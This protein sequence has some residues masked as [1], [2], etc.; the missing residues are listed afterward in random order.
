MLA[1]VPGNF[2]LDDQA[3]MVVERSIEQ[4][5]EDAIRKLGVSCGMVK[6]FLTREQVA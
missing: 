5:D 1:R 6:I 2:V 3:G 4:S